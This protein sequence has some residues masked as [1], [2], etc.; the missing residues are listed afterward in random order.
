[1][2][3]ESSYNSVLHFGG[4]AASGGSA[5][6][7]LFYENEEIFVFPAE[8]RLLKEKDGILDLENSLFQSKSP[9][10]IDLSI[11]DF[12]KLSKNLGRVNNK[13]RRR[14]FNY[15][16]FTKGQY[17]FFI[18]DFINEITDYLYFQNT[19]NFDFRKNYINSQFERYAIKIL[20]YSLFEQKSYMSCPKYEEFILSVRKMLRGI[21]ESACKT[22]DK[23]PKVIA[24]H[25]AVNHFTEYSIENSA[26]YFDDFKMILI[27]RDPRD[28]FIDLP[29]NR[30]I[31]KCNDQL[32]RAKC[33][34]KFF[35]SLRSNLSF[36]KKYE[37]CLLINFEDLI[38]NS[39]VT[40]SIINNFLGIK[41]NCNRTKN[42]YFVPSI[43]KKNI[44]KYKYLNENY[45]LAIKYIEDQLAEYLYDH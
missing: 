25:N 2:K 42:K 23:F 19:H 1:M 15:D 45:K 4:F 37:N 38:L 21:F 30:Y 35:N 28:I 18:K 27:D 29:R 11:K 6:R 16:S 32:Y 13:F 24:L 20:P 43:S 17:S 41:E 44:K 12:L 36:I 5:L 3:S 9:D 39:Q 10:N 7:D 22:Y 8:F 26:K 34:V 33:F 31:P 14:G 40:I